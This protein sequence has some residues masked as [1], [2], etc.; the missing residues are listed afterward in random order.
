MRRAPLMF[1]LAVT[2][3]P[4][5]AAAEVLDTSDS[6]AAGHVR[7]M[8]G[9]EFGLADPNPIRL[10]IQE[11]IGL[12]SGL[13]IYLV[14]AIGLHREN[15]ARLGGGLKWTVLPRKKDRPGIALWGGGFYQTA[16]EVAGVT[17]RFLIDYR[18]G[19]VT[20]YG[21]LDLDLWFQDGVDSH[22]TV[23]GGARVSI[24]PHVAAFF[25]AGADLTGRRRDHVA[26][27]GLALEI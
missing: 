9:A 8:A 27:L 17:G 1:T 11:R 19:R 6:L 13:D 24:V 16:M 21:A 20:P 3:L 7:V 10:D 18:F 15:G 12:A 5:L 26:A 14:Q 2:V 22:L 25:E 4:G 23:L